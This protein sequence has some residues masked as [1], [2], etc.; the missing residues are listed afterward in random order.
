[1]NEAIP[2]QVLQAL[3][4]GLGDRLI[5]VVLFGSR[6]R[7]DADPTSDWD[8]LVVARDLPA[9][10]FQRHLYLKRLLP[11]EWRGQ[12][13]ILAKT[14]E[15]LDSHLSALLLDIALDGRILY[16]TQNYMAERL[17]YLRSLIREQGL[18]R[19][20]MGRDMAWHWKRPPGLDW[21][22]EWRSGQ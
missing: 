11:E 6:A 14:P 20:Q 13:A 19:I 2:N 21:S 7:G 9:K 5:A 10:V 12:V 22:L 18:Y 4:H 17:A 3:Q 15:E 16:D 1:M 8:L